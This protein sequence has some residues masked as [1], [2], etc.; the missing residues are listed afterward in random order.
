MLLAACGSNSSSNNANLNGHWS[1]SMTS[2]G[3]SN[4]MVAFTTDLNTTTNNSVT[5]TNLNFTTNDGCFDNKNAT[6]N[7]S[8]TLSGN[9]NGN[10]N[11]GFGM[12]VTSPATGAS[13]NNTLTL[14]GTVSNGNTISGTWTLT[15]MQSGCTGSGTFSM[16]KQLPQ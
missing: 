11:G 5:G 16:T 7:G 10:V 12:T 14:A 6:A 2:Q 9:D 13:G 3:S 1:A 15:G 4:P 8:F